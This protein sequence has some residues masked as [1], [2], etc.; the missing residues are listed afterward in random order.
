MLLIF[1]LGINVFGV[2]L[3]FIMNILLILMWFF[4]KDILFI[5]LFLFICIGLL[6]IILIE[7]FRLFEFFIR[8]FF[9]YIGIK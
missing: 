9:L 2:V 5:S 6:C 4:L 7:L 8:L 1:I 3:F